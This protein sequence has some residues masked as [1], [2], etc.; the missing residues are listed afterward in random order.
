MMSDRLDPACG[1]LRHM[2]P[3]Q[4]PENSFSANTFFC[5]AVPCFINKLALPTDNKPE[6]ML[7]EAMAKNEFAAASRV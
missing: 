6:P 4:R 2:V 5:A 7:I 1:S 3:D